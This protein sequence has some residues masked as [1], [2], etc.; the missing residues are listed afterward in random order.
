[1]GSDVKTETAAD[2]AR[3]HFRATIRLGLYL[4]PFVFAVVTAISHAFQKA[5]L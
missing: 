3:A 5:W 1:M 2:M 4:T